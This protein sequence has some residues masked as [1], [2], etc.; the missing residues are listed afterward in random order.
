MLI[1]LADGRDFYTS[2]SS[3]SPSPSD[4]STSFCLQ[5]HAALGYLRRG[6]LMQDCVPPIR[7][8]LAAE[9]SK[10]EAKMRSGGRGGE[11]ET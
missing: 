7:D 11:E 3:Q 9:I 8:F 2:F 4:L 6:E 5:H 10:Y 1:S